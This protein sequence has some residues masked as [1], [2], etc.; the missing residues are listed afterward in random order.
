LQLKLH[1]EVKEQDDNSHHFIQ[2]LRP[3]EHE[4]DRSYYQFSSPF[5]KKQEGQA[6]TEDKLIKEQVV[7]VQA[8][9]EKS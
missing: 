7:Q 4:I 8:K 6:P 2:F 3:H 5:F 1:S 9:G